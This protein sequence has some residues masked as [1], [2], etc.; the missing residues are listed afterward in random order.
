MLKKLQL[1]SGVNRENTRYT[2]EGGWYDCDKIRFRQGT[3]EKIGGWQQLSANS[4]NGTCRSLWPWA[5]LSYATYLGVGTNTKYYNMVGGTFNDITPIQTTTAAGAVTFAATNGSST[6]TVT[7]AAHGTTVNTF[8]TFSGAVSLGGNITA[9]VLNAEYQ[10][11]S[12]LSANTYTITATATAN[13]SDVGNGG[14][15][16]VGAYQVSAG[17]ANQTPTSGWGAGGWGL[18]AWG[19][20]DSSTVSLRVWNAQNFGENLIYGPV[21]GPM[22]YWKAN[23]SLTTRGTLLSAEVGATD[24]PLM[25]N[26]IIISDASRIVIAFGVNDYGSSTQDPMLIRWSDQESAINWTSVATTQ[27]GSLRLSHGSQIITAL[28]VRQEIL[29]WTDTSL[30]SMQYLTSEPWWGVQLL[31]DNISIISNR[32]AAYSGGV[33]YWMGA[34]KFYAYDG[35]TQTLPCDLRQYVFEDFNN[36]Q[37]QQVFATTVEKFNEI[38]WFYCSLNSDTI[39][40]Y[41][42][43]NYLEKLWY[44]GTMPRTAWIDSSI[45]S[46]YPISASNGKLIYQEY[47]TDDNSTG[48]P[49]P[50]TAFITSAEFDIDDGDSLG[51]VWRV[52]PDITFRGSSAANPAATMYLL[53][54]QNSGSGYNNNTSTNSNQSVAGD[55]SGAITRIGTYPVEQFTGQINTRVRGR[56][57][58]I[59]VESTALGVQ[60]QLGAPR[61]DIR[62]DGRK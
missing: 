44:Y 22:Y 38:W 37:E 31:S 15:A 47:G 26:Q 43:F 28:Q 45:I 12:V 13:A 5:S 17:F 32:A 49:A 27:A 34:D 30:Y 61:I 40:K 9:T 11:V 39:D 57:M 7:S 10:V 59:K 8:V 3:P 58:S 6:I 4:Y 55:S 16:V 41:V 50:I 52:I 21:G 19:V 60:W 46:H 29:V 35:R 23:T 54:L 51:F 53:P 24:V 36:D 1:K 14:S 56:Q 20:G 42:V 18:G 33:T 62:P 25:Q 2:N 48:T